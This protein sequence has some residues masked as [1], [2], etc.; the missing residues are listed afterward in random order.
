MK[1]IVIPILFLLGGCVTHGNL[2]RSSPSPGTQDK[3]LQNEIF[4]AV[5]QIWLDQNKR[6]ESIYVS[7]STYAIRESEL[8]KFTACANN[9]TAR[10]VTLVSEPITKMS[11][12][13]SNP[14]LYFINRHFWLMPDPKQISKMIEEGRPASI[15]SLSSIAFDAEKS[16][17]VLQFSL[18]CGSLCGYGETLVFDR[19]TSGWVQRP[20]TC[21]GWMS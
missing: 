4:H 20:A 5:L 19:T 1:A 12:S 16:V 11:G 17:A 8:Q 13:I 3:N 9:G 2:A 10:N 7:K 21:D 14:R 15:I 6:G 18:A